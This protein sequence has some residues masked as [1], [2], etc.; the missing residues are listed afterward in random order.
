MTYDFNWFTADGAECRFR[1]HARIGS[2][3]LVLSRLRLAGAIVKAV[4]VVTLPASL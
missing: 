2:F 3:D 4:V 1:V